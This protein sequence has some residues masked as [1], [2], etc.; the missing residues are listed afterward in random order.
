MHR[1]R[2]RHIRILKTINFVINL[3]WVSMAWR[4]PVSEIR[5]QLSK[6]RIS[7]LLSTQTDRWW[8]KVIGRSC[9]FSNQ[10]ANVF[11][12]SDQDKHQQI[13]EF[14]WPGIWEKKYSISGVRSFCKRLS[15]KAKNVLVRYKQ[16]GKALPQSIGKVVQEVAL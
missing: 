13:F 3:G 12:L 8:C 15:I 11:L 4:T 1:D 9:K 2:L 5:E 6:R 10:S 14:V 16:P 7:S